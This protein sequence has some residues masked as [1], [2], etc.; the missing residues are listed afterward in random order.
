M[1]SETPKPQHDSSRTPGKGRPTRTRKEA[2]AARRRPLV[3]EDRKEARQRDRERRRALAAKENQAMMTGD[4]RHMPAQHRGRDRRLVRDVVDSRRNVGEF[5]VPVALVFMLVTLILPLLNP[6]LYGV[7]STAVMIVVWGG[8]ALVILD[9][10]ILRGRLRKELT[11]K[12]GAVPQGL[13]TYG[14]L[15]ALQ[16]RPLRLPRP[17]VKHGGAPMPPKMPQR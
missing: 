13:V 8:I 11:E 1:T 2:Q 17:M 14:I 9:S 16:L 5:F 4:E 6:Q 3:V 12:F 10:I 7:A 15:R